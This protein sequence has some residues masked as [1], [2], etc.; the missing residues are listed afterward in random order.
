MKRSLLTLVAA[1]GTV[2]L[3]A[4]VYAAVALATSGSGSVASIVSSGNLQGDLAYNTGLAPGNGLT[5][6]G[7]QFSPEQL[8]EFLIALRKSGVANLG[9]WLAAHPGAAAKLGLPAVALLKSPYIVTQTIK[10]PPGAYSGWHSHPGYLTA[11][12]ISGEV[13]R[14]DAA[15][16]QSQKFTAGQSLY[17]TG[18][19]TFF[20]RN[21]GTADAV[22]TATYVVPSG[23][24]NTGLRID[25]PQ[26]AN[27][28][29]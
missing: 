27:C 29:P 15:G 20:V 3:A 1:G 16:C 23:T 7:K 11:T 14:Y 6:K 26:P 13:V 17:E 10:Y 2:A 28:K 12:V 18:A 24:P 4:V 5:W 19:N 21:E 22:L 8:P 9:D 25:K